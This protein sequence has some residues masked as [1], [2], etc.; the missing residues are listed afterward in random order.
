MLISALIGITTDPPL[1]VQ[2]RLKGETEVSVQLIVPVTPPLVV[3]V[4]RL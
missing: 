4:P 3:T 2:L 1:A